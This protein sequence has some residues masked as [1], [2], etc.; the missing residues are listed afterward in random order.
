MCVDFAEDEGSVF[1]EKLV[2]ENRNQGN[3]DGITD[4]TQLLDLASCMKKA[5]FDNTSNAA[6]TAAY[7]SQTSGEPICSFGYAEV[8][9][10]VTLCMNSTTIADL[11]KE[12][13]ADRFRD[14]IDV[15]DAQ[16]YWTYLDSGCSVFETSARRLLQETTTIDE[17]TDP[18]DQ[19]TGLTETP[20]S[21]PNS[22]N[23]LPIE[24]SITYAAQASYQAD[25]DKYTSIYDNI[26]KLLPSAQ[27]T[28]DSGSVSCCK[29]D[30]VCQNTE[31]SSVAV[32]AFFA[33]IAAVA[34]F[35]LV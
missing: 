8:D 16:I 23:C 14:V 1:Y 28:I 18:W 17:I 34:T 11:C 19:I 3:G 6:I 22:Q 10:A 5:C 29:E 27:V 33:I 35:L 25:K 4:N 7:K 15:T 2:R 30:D 20:E 13:Y 26:D 21:I 9:Y 31:S 12:N 24:I 32:S